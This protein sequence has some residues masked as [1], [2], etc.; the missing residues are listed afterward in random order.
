MPPAGNRNKTKVNTIRLDHE[1]LWGPTSSGI[2]RHGLFLLSS[3]GSTRPV[4]DRQA[5]RSRSV[6]QLERRWVSI[7]IVPT[8][9]ISVLVKRLDHSHSVVI[10]QHNRSE[11]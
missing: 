7:I 2:S 10:F 5:G 1:R 3:R 9:T 8:I 11:L 6:Q 4:I